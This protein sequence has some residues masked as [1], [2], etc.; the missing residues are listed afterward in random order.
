M[1]ATIFISIAVALAFAIVIGLAIY[2][3]KYDNMKGE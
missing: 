3:G 1:T 2:F